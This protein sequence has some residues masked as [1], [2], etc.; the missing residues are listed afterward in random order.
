MSGLIKGTFNTWSARP[1]LNPGAYPRGDQ[2]EAIMD[3][4]SGRSI[5]AWGNRSGNSTGFTTEIGVLRLDNIAV[6]IN[7]M[8]LIWCPPIHIFST[9]ANDDVSGV[10]RYT[11]DGTAATTASTALHSD[12]AK[13]SGASVDRGG[14]VAPFGVLVPSADA[15]MSVLLSGVRTN[16][17][18]TCNLLATMNLLVEACGTAPADTGV[19]L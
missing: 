19:D 16:G 10:L 9:V 17:T 3:E 13:V 12:P 8:Y 14:S 4:I 7:R 6:E 15:V 11:L 1:G 5:I 2:I 18:G